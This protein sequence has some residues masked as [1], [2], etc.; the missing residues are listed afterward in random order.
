MNFN[1]VIIKKERVLGINVDMVDRQTTQDLI[2]KI[3][4]GPSSKKAIHLVTAYSEFFLKAQHDKNFRQVLEGAD[5][6]VPDGVGPLAAIE[7]RRSLGPRD[8]VLERFGKGL[9]IGLRV[10][11][12]KVGE[13]VSGVWLF[14]KLVELASERGWKVFLLG[15][16]EGVAAQLENKLR[17]R[18]PQLEIMSYEGEL[19]D[20]RITASS[21]SQDKINSF[22]PDI[23]FVAYGPVKQ[24]KWLATNKT[25]LRVKI[26]I[27]VGGTFD[28]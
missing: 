13:V 4:E 2:C 7:Y 8:G 18:Y 15:G 14:E 6:V 17:K 25:K 28:E 19:L 23:L 10:L 24:E 3:I 1:R 27:G 11:Q 5:L 26:A 20:E 16:Y 21:D 22:K 12:G 9:K